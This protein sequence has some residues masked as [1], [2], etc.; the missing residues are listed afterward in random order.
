VRIDPPCAGR[1]VFPKFTLGNLSTV[2]QE[3]VNMRFRAFLAAAA[4]AALASTE[5]AAC[6][7]KFLV[8][9]RGVQYT[10]VRAA[11]HPASILIYMNP[12]HRMPASARQ[13]QLEAGLKQAGHKVQTVGD[14]TG[15][16]GA[17]KAKRFDLVIADVND[18]NGLEQ[19]LGASARTTVV[20]VLFQPTAE[21]LAAAEKRYGCALKAPGKS[22]D[23]LD[24]IDAALAP[25]KAG[26]AQ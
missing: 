25:R 21:E 22:S 10:R 1:Y 6:G 18:S 12:A 8:V 13:L 15:L 17:L 7:D 2:A 19:E 11:A 3:E 14:A 26:K 20:P 5:A 23:Y 9:G 16:E 24:V 4:L